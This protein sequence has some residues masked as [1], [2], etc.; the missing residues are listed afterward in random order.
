MVA[1]GSLGKIF[2]MDAG[3]SFPSTGGEEGEVGVVEIGA[4]SVAASLAFPRLWIVLSLR[5]RMHRGK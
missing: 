1:R 4:I 3:I 5:T 2:A